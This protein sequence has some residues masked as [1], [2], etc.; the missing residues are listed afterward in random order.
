ME[1]AESIR[2]KEPLAQIL[3][4]FKEKDAVLEYRYT[5]VVKLAGHSCPTVTGAW[6]CCLYA[7]KSLYP[8][9]I[10]VRGEISITVYGEPDEGVYGV[11]SQV[12]GFITGAATMTGFKGLGTRFKR[13]DLLVFSNEKPDPQALCFRFTR[14][15]NGRTVLVKFY[16]WLIPLP[17]EKAKRT[18]ELMENVISGG[19]SVQE[20]GEFQD[21]WMEKIQLML[22][23]RKE[24]ED[25]LK[26]E[27][28][29]DEN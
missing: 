27:V 17:Q 26:V 10:P 11:M 8:D 23:E 13:K 3:G 4:A 6:L 2:L 22:V 9:E 7:L 14:E 12:F 15:D 24:I 25:W 28:D 29:L 5:D 20:S 21:L 1:Q 19:A 16:P 18:A